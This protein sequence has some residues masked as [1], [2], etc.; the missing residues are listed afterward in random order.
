MPIYYPDR[1]PQE[2]VVDRIDTKPNEGQFGKNKEKEERLRLEEKE[3]ER[4]RLAEEERRR[5]EE[6]ERQ[7]EY[8]REDLENHIT[9]AEPE[10][11]TTTTT[12][13]PTK[14]RP[15]KQDPIC[16][17]PVEPELDVDFD[18]GYRF[19]TTGDSRIEFTQIRPNVKKAYDFALQ[20]N[21]AEPNGVLFYA[22]DEYHNDFIALYLKNG[23]VSG[24]PRL[25][26]VSFLLIFLCLT[27]SL[28]LSSAGAF[29]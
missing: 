12:I 27:L 8:D 13:R 7:R 11:L 15:S 20:F 2:Q 1:S 19:G 26:L 6:E 14:R 9:P 29:I 23:Y 28:S 21:T 18:A 10:Y 17:L 24:T 3:R 16:K 5:K 25:D 22:E 4:Q